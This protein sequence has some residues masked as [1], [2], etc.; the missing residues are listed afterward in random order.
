MPHAWAG[1]RQPPTVDYIKKAIPS[2]DGTSA[3]LSPER[4]EDDTG[5]S[6]PIHVPLE[7]IE[8]HLWQWLRL[9]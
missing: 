9:K 4:I 3:Y 5:L 1:T 2:M 7:L 8:R 6:N